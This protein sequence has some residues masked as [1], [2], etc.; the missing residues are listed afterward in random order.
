[1]LMQKMTS[2]RANE[3][4]FALAVKGLG[5]NFPRLQAVV[6]QTPPLKKKGGD[7]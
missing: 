1:M 2:A 4:R 6:F 3:S 5:G 7:K